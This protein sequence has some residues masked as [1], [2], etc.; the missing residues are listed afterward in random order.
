MR[1]ELK[2]N[3]WIRQMIWATKYGIW[4]GKRR[5]QNRILELIKSYKYK[6]AFTY[7]NLEAMIKSGKK[8]E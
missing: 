8:Y 6:P 1:R 4:L 3:I 2:P 5:E 7:E